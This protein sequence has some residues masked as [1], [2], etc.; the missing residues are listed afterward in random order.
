MAIKGKYVVICLRTPGTSGD[1][2]PVAGVTSDRIRVNGETIEKAS[3]TS[4]KWKEFLAG[5]M[6]WGINSDY[7][8]TSWN[9]ISGNPMKVGETYAIKVLDSMNSDAYL[10]GTVICT[11]C[12][13]D[14]RNGSLV[15]GSF[16][17]QGT[18]P[19]AEA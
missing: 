8:V 3:A 19:L 16:S 4:S 18:G 15:K 17:F 10:L 13:I 6:D 11:E 2:T 14:M 5:R 9:D 12:V 1:G 7:L